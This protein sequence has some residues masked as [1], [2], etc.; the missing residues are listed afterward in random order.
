MTFGYGIFLATSNNLANVI[1]NSFESA[2][3]FSKPRMLDNFIVSAFNTPQ[4]TLAVMR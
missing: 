4:L 1:L 3:N 2:F